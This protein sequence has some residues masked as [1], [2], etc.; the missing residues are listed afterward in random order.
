MFGEVESNF[1]LHIFCQLGWFKHQLDLICETLGE[2]LKLGNTIRIY[3][4][5]EVY[6]VS[7]HFFSLIHQVVLNNQRVSR[8]RSNSCDV[9][10][11][12]QKVKLPIVIVPLWN[13]FFGNP[14]SLTLIFV[15]SIKLRNVYYSQYV[16]AVGS[17]FSWYLVSFAAQKM[18]HLNHRR[19][20]KLKMPSWRKVT[21]PT[22]W[23]S[24][25]NHWRPH[26]SFPPPNGGLAR[27]MGPLI[28]GKP[29]W[30]K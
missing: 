12:L 20:N 23:K 27:E 17:I 10:K 30:V 5:L 8:R 16:I 19:R 11:P 1:D 6:V 3:Q 22:G 15:E 25:E 2:A 28:L 7:C 26:T 21:R 14:F 18:A 4:I 13:H 24:L 9:Y 29:R